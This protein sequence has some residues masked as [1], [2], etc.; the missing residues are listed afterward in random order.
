MEYEDTILQEL[1]DTPA[2]LFD[3]PEFKEDVFDLDEI[4]QNLLEY[5]MTPPNLRGKDDKTK[6]RLY[7]QMILQEKQ[8]KQFCYKPYRTIHNY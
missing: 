4:N 6:D 2:E 8:Q 1:M 3:L 5:Q 7:Q